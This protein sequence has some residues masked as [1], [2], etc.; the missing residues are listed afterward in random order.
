M[1]RNSIP[2]TVIAIAVL[3]G[4]IALPLAARAGEEDNLGKVSQPLVGGSL[5]DAATQERYGLLTLDTGCSASLLRN[6]WVITAAHCIDDPVNGQ[7][8]MFTNV[9][10]DSVSVT[11]DWA[12]TQKRQSMRIISLR[13]LDIAI[14]RVAK[15]FL[16][17]GASSG[18]N[19][20]VFQGQLQSIPLRV[21]GRGIMQFAQ[22]GM[23][24]QRDSLYRVGNFTSGSSASDLYQ[25]ASSANQWVACG[26]SGGPSFTPGSGGELLVGVHSAAAV[27]CVAGKRCG[28]WTGPGAAPGNYNP[29]DWVASTSN[30]VD[31]PVAA[32]WD[33]IDRYLGAFV[34]LATEQFIGTFGT[35]PANYQPIW[36]Y[37]IKADGDL[38]WYR[39][40]SGSAPWQG[41]KKVGNGW[42]GFKDV[43]PAGGNG[44]YALT[45]DGHLKWYRHD[46]FNEGS[47]NWQGPVDVGR[48]WSFS[49]IFSGGDGIVYAIKDDGSLVWYRHGGYADGGGM[50]TWTGPKT[51]G[52]GWNG[53][54]DVFSEGNGIIY[55][56]KP[57]G[58]LLLYRHDGYAT[59][60]FKWQQPRTIGSAWQ[61]FRQV[62]P[63][64]GGVLLAIRDDGR[65]LWYRYRQPRAPQPGYIALGRVRSEFEGPTQIGS[66]WQG[67]RKVFALLPS[68]TLQA[69]R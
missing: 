29:W 39:K 64:G 16:V 34:P 68:T 22:G 67:F 41:P 53:F 5:I 32:A 66:G 18:Y 44:M 60:E 56:I 33:E 59:G 51:V 48:G 40:D 14:I 52:T 21:F 65:L 42:G 4:A 6:E 3:T 37:A 19:R 20:D 9:P 31:A 27:Q 15:P 17:R 7:P 1:I 8:G 43:I 23:P 62:V 69:P 28:A 57:D 24:A 26:D 13:P 38:V 11:A 10:E 46:G 47:F 58:M 61:Q 36:V 25:I 12:S 35:T 45:A 2:A 30:A 49:K 55:A 50:N 63:A 54:K